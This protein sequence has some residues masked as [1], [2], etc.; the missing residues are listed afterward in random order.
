LEH[1]QTG[2]T[3]MTSQV[4][5]CSDCQ[6]EFTFS[7]EEQ[8]FF[9]EK[10]FS[11]P[12]RCKSCRQAAKQARAGGGGSSYDAPRPGGYGAPR[13]DRQM[14]DVTC[15]QCGKNTQVPF[16]PNG[17]RPVYCRDCFQR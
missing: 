17:S 15:A 12:R 9:A 1:Q 16:K 2:E 11:T 5:A 8:Q 7:A 3:E 14:Y 6:A 10:G 4:L 13:G